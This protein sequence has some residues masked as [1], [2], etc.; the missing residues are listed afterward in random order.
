M[1]A[2]RRLTTE[3]LPHK[4]SG[5]LTTELPP[6]EMSG[7]LVRLFGIKILNNGV[8]GRLG[9]IGIV[10]SIAGLAILELLIRARTSAQTNGGP[11]EQN[12]SRARIK[13]LPRMAAIA[14]LRVGAKE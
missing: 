2:G 12:G 10:R 9:T 6:Q 7:G 13:A 5:R 3:L 4:M 8:N 1:S 11:A 14:G